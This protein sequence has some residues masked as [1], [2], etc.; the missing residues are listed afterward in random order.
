MKIIT[1]AAVAVMTVTVAVSV[2][3]GSSE[4]RVRCHEGFRV[5]KD[6]RKLSTPLCQDLYLA[7]VARE[8]GTRVSDREILHNPN[9]RREICEFVGWD[10]RVKHLCDMVLPRRNGL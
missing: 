9:R 8:F 10:I 3:P 6:G 2:M 1:G 4:A 5:Y 7:Q